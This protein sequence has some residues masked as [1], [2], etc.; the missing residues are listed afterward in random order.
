M[1]VL[2]RGEHV[3]LYNDVPYYT[4]G[5]AEDSSAISVEDAIR[6]CEASLTAYFGYGIKIHDWTTYSCPE[7]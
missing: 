4:V 7:E 3:S 1:K 6:L 5:S 2:I